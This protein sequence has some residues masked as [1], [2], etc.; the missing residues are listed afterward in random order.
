M[1]YPFKQVYTLDTKRS[2]QVYKN[3]A[4]IKVPGVTTILGMLDKPALVYWAW[5]LGCEGKDYK[6]VSGEAADIGTI[7]H[8]LCECH[9]RNMTL[10]ETNL[11]KDQLDKAQNAFIKFLDWWEREGF[12]CVDSELQMVS[13]RWQ[14]GGTADIVARDKNGDLVLID[15][16]TSKAIYREY[17]MQVAAYAAMYEEITG[18]A[19][20]RI[21]IVRIG[22]ED[23]GDFETREVFD[24]NLCEVAFESLCG[25][26]AALKSV[27]Q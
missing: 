12:E 1:K 16:K 5:K 25:S 4:G 2:H 13:E 11:P 18:E 9:V 23:V 8:A 27:K 24:R 17:R 6:K 19:I 22:K 15:L 21:I 7:A 14:V 26:Y 10:D 20:S 3:A